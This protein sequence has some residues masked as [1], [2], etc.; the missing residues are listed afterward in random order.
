MP[1]LMTKVGHG[2]HLGATLCA[3][4]D[5][6]AAEDREWV[7]YFPQSLLCEFILQNTGRYV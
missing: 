1:Q 7:R 5:S 6:M 2:L 3:I 4:H